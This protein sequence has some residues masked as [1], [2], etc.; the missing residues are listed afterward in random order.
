MCRRAV[1]EIWDEAPVKRTPAEWALRW[2]WNHPD[3]TVVLSGMN[4]ES[5]IR[6]NIRVAGEV[7][8]HSL[9]E[10]ELQLVQR[11]EKNYP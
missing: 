6:E 11:V 1:Q 3:V 9:N 10:A 5:H 8:P 2:I 4:D 7:Y